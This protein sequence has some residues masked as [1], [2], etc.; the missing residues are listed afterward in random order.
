M[1]ALLL[2]QNLSSRLV[3]DLERF[4]PGTA[5]VRERGL[6]R[7]SDRDV[8]DY[9]AVEG[10]AIVSKDGDFRHLALTLGAPPKVIWARAGNCSTE[11]ILDVLIRN[12]ETIAVF[13]ADPVEALLVLRL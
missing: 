1:A 6:D 4:F 3:A 7:A 13:L 12:V 10:L 11:Q 8:W 9:A 2:D 5:H